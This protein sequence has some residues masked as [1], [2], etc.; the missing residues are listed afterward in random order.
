MFANAAE[1]Y[2]HFCDQHPYHECP[3]RLG[4]DFYQCFVCQKVMASQAALYTHLKLTHKIKLNGKEFKLKVDAVPTKCTICDLI[5]NSYMECIDH[6]LD[7][8]GLEIPTELRMQGGRGKTRNLYCV[9]CSF[10]SKKIKLY[11]QHRKL[12]Q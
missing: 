2:K 12:H 8:H 5:L 10:E 9:Q 1:L 4:V 7:N 11:A 6:I 3:V